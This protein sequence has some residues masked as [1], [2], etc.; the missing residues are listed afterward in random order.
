MVGTSI[1]H[2]HIVESLGKGGMGEVYA[3]EDT[4]L[5]RRVALKRAPPRLF[6]NVTIPAQWSG[7]GKSLLFLVVRGG[8]SN[9]WRQPIAGG[10][11]VPVTKFS[12]ERRF[13]FNASPDQKRWA[14]VRGNIASDVVLVTE[15]E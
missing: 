9:V 1:G 4:R 6:P 8:A 3:A 2:Y 11:A 7:D 13:R 12:D 10:P 15:R 5:G 14:I